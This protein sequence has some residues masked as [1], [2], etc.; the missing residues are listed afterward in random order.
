MNEIQTVENQILEQLNAQQEVIP[1]I[2][3]VLEWVEQAIDLQMSQV[4]RKD[5]YAVKYAVEPLLAGS[6]PLS[7]LPVRIKLVYALGV[8]TRNEY[9]DIELLRTLYGKLRQSQNHCDFNDTVLLE[10]LS[11]LHCLQDYP[12][13]LRPA[14]TLEPS[15]GAMQQQ[16]QRQIVHSTL[17]L[18]LTELISRLWQK[19]AF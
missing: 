19:K 15:L 10:Q 1:F 2:D 17:V 5:D 14:S 7:D 13:L 6:G 3:T 9:E 16:R 18:C 12:S 8:I 4:F 11:Q